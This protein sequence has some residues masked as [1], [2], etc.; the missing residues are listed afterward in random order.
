[1]SDKTVDKYYS[2]VSEEV[3]DLS[4]Q[5]RAQYMPSKKGD[6]K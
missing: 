4:E 5:C 3:I 2:G 1:M 6:G